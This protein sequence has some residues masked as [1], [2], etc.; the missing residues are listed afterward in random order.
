VPEYAHPVSY[1]MG[2]G[3]P[4]SGVK[5]PGRETDCS[6][7]SSAEVKNDAAIF[8]L[9]QTQSRHVRG[10]FTCTWT[11]TDRSSSNRKLVSLPIQPTNGYDGAKERVAKLI[12]VT[13]ERPVSVKF[14]RKVKLLGTYIE[15]TRSRKQTDQLCN[16]IYNILLTTFFL[17][18]HRAF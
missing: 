8:R 2:I 14:E 7:P 1:S 13:A 18:L 17:L 6:P 3:G 11:C 10:N 12:I 15:T 9:P 4:F 16:H 5:R